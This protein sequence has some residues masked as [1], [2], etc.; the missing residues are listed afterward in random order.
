MDCRPPAPGRLLRRPRVER[1]RGTR[2]QALAEQSELSV[3]ITVAPWLAAGDF[4]T[5][6]IPALERLRRPALS[7]RLTGAC[8][9][10]QRRLNLAQGCARGQPGPSISFS[11]PE[12]LSRIEDGVGHKSEGGDPLDV[13]WASRSL[14]GGHPARAFLTE[15]GRSP[16]PAGAVPALSSRFHSCFAHPIDGIPWRICSKSEGAEV[17]RWGKFF[18]A[19]TGIRDRFRLSCQPY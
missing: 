7:L 3:L 12:R 17:L 14:L 19:E 18:A 13:G 8:A 5:P 16:A 15:A 2:P 11:I 10:P 1:P 6:L 9:L 4:R